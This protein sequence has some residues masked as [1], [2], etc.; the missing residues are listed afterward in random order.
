M[1]TNFCSLNYPI[2][3]IVTQPEQINTK[4]GRYYTSKQH[5]IFFT[6]LIKD[7]YNVIYFYQVTF[8]H[9]GDSW[10]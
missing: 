2:C 8:R 4:T 9:N 10:F 3:K 6:T 7:L 1:R 5:T